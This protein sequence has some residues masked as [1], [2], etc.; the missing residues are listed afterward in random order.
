MYFVNSLGTR[1]LKLDGVQLTKKSRLVER[2]A[3]DAEERSALSLFKS[4]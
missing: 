2:G 1:L 4:V 3:I